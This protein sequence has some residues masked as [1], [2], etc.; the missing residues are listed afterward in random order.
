MG[1]VWALDCKSSLDL[2]DP[3]ELPRCN[4]GGGFEGG[5][6]EGSLGF[7]LLVVCNL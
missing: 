1:E 5:G 6:V 2:G 4:S 3:G 7:I